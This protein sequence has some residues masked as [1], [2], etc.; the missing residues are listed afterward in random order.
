MCVH[1]NKLFINLINAVVLQA[2][3]ERKY[4]EKSDVYSYGMVLFEIWS[5]GRKPLPGKDNNTVK[6]HIYNK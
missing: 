3:V 1:E 2:L 4:S 6:R 5:I